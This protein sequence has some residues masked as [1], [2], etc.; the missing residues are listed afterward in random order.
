MKRYTGRCIRWR[1]AGSARRAPLPG[2]GGHARG[3]V[4]V[5]PCARDAW[6]AIVPVDELDQALARLGVEEACERGHGEA[7]LHALL[8]VAVGLDAAVEGKADAGRQVRAT[9]GGPGIAPRRAP[10]HQEV[11]R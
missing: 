2:R 9:A 3:G 4:C 11:S 10:P 7:A 1:D 5:H 6:L 8:H